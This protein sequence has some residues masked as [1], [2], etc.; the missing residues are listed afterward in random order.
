[1]QTVETLASNPKAMNLRQL[2]AEQNWERLRFIEL[3]CTSNS[4]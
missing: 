1:M 3:A 2:I 4:R